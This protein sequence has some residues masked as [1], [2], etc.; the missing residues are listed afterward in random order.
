MSKRALVFGCAGQDGSFC[1]DLLLSKDYEVYGFARRSSSD[2]LWR[3]RHLFDRPS[4]NYQRG[5]TLLNGDITDPV[6]ICRAVE[7]AE[8]TEV[9]NFA[10]QDS[11]EWSRPNAHYQNSVTT[12]AVIS[13]MEILRE[14]DLHHTLDTVPVK[15]FQPLSVTMFGNSPTPWNEESKL[16]PQTPYAVAKAA[17]WQWCKFYRE[18]RGLDVRCAIFGNHD[19]PRRRG[20]Y[21]LQT[22]CKQA[23]EVKAGKCKA[24]ELRNPEA[25]V[26]VGYA[27]EYVEAAW[28]IMQLEKPD[29]FV[30][31]TGCTYRAE[32]LANYALTHKFGRTVG[33]A[34]TQKLLEPRKLEKSIDCRFRDRNAL[35]V[36]DEILE[37]EEWKR[38]V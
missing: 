34:K 12:G 15:F 4:T 9:Y 10:D 30:V 2:N 28:R 32:E 27:P 6:A 8:P 5:F 19:S 26:D 7:G 21:L 36:I 14:R 24:I 18:R 3:I 13:M 33:F 37:N 17:T 1:C 23:L 16:D 22:I 11:P 29:D 38:C 25:V 31:A 20:N 35:D